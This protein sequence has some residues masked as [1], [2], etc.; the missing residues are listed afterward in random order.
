MILVG[1]LWGEPTVRTESRRKEGRRPFLIEEINHR[2]PLPYSPRR[3][4][5]GPTQETLDRWVSLPLDPGRETT[6]QS[7]G[8]S[9]TGQPF[10]TLGRYGLRPPF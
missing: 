5:D 8:P 9:E 7:T 3:V 6:Y 10:W 1:N 4:G 2:N